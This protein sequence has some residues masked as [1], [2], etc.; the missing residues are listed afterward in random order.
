[1]KTK[2]RWNEQKRKE[3]KETTNKYA[4]KWNSSEQ[5]KT[6]EKQKENLIKQKKNMKNL[7][8]NL[9][10]CS[11]HSLVG[12]IQTLLH[13]IMTYIHKI[14]ESFLPYQIYSIACFQYGDNMRAHSNGRI[15]FLAN[16][17]VYW[18]FL[19]KRKKKSNQLLPYN[20]FGEH[21]YSSTLHM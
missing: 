2:S 4:K 18:R 15:L 13:T 16:K 1:M 3:K 8:Q 20:L 5:K 6:N 17:H 7:W 14:I 9:H 11:F 21:T 19:F 10:K 12:R